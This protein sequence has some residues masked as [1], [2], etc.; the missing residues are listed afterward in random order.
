MKFSSVEEVLVV[1]P[2][3]VALVDELSRQWAVP[4]TTNPEINEA[5]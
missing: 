5:F 2:D 3:P 4:H 1:S